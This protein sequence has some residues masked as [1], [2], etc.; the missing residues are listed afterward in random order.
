VRVIVS[1]LAALLVFS[2]GRKG[3]PTLKSYEKPP[4]PSQL[5]AI[6]EEDELIFSWVYPDS[7]RSSI[8]GFYLLKSEDASF[9]R[10][11]FITPD[12]TSFTDRNFGLNITWKYKVIAVNPRD[13]ASRDSNTISVTP[14][15]LPQP[16]EKIWFTVGSDS[17][18]L[19]WESAGKD[20]CYTIFR[21]PSKDA[22]RGIQI[23]R[24]PVC[25]LEYEEDILPSAIVYYR[26]RPV[27]IT[28][29]ENEGYASAALEVNPSHFVPSPPSDL[30]IVKGDDR[31]Y[32]MWKESPESWVKGY[33]VY[34]RIEGEPGVTLVGE[35]ALP[36]FTDMGKAGKRTWYMIRAL[37]PSAESEPLVAEMP[38]N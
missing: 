6:H 38:G 32:L 11:A 23:N 25:K 22:S 26:I 28:E 9:E 29:I 24:E 4:A 10:Y 21:S 35:V 2:C 37:G 14:K 3:P 8:K 1:G 30:R 12:K 18:T 17:L 5:M 20:I 13:I 27:L 36:S 33:R 16:P 31:V 34:R 19:H 7:L 15:P